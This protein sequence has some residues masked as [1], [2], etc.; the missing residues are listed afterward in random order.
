VA[1]GGVAYAALA[2]RFA[3]GSV[4]VTAAV[5]KFIAPQTFARAVEGY[6]IL[7]RRGVALTARGVPAVE[8]VLG[9]ALLAGVAVPVAASGSS[10]LFAV[11]ASVVAL[12][13]ARGRRND[14]G[15]GGAS[16]RQIGWDLVIADLALCAVSV[17]AGARASDALSAM[18]VWQAASSI[19]DG[20]AF[21][22]LLVTVLAVLA[23]SLV[24][25]QRGT[26]RTASTLRLD[27]VRSGV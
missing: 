2:C 23:R 20:E 12:N 25:A 10:A 17:F 9:T 15:C 26:H 3:V 8:L 27:R 4:L 11:F 18:P 22:V 14:C 1:A 19:Q 13:L 24:R 6:G 7:P 16:P 21:A 5:S